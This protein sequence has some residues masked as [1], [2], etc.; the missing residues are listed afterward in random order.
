MSKWFSAVLTFEA[1]INGTSEDDGLC[2]ASI[3]LVEA[4]DIDVAQ[5]KARELGWELEHDY[6]NE[7]GEQVTWRFRSVVEV[8][9][10]EEETIVDGV[11]VFSRLYRTHQP[12][13]ARPFVDYA[14]L[15][16]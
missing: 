2:E 14:L 8:Q 1:E 11:E 12:E 6:I 15:K 13:D 5:E 10:V 4:S 16:R 7:N 9:E 3:R